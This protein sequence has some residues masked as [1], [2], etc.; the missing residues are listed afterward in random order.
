MAR[1]AYGAMIATLV[2][3]VAFIAIGTISWPVV[4]G[5]QGVGI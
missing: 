5:Y 2:A 4:T 3:L 1:S